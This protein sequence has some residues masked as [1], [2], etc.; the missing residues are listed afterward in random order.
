MGLP[1]MEDGRVILAVTGHRP[2]KIRVGT[3]NA[4]DPAVQGG[5]VEFA[6][7]I[8]EQEA[9][10]LVVT[11]MAQGWDQAVAEACLNTGLPYLAAVP[12]KEQ[13]GKWPEKAQ[14]VYYRL[15]SGAREIRYVSPPGFDVGK[16]HSRNLWM[17]DNGDRLLALYNGSGGGTGVCVRYALD[18]AKPVRNVWDDW[19]AFVAAGVR[20]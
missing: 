7:G 5:L 10:S 4:Y 13:A 12:F 11:G 2:D 3:K 15:L 20:A 1:R 6:T 8:L 14:K 18:V 16:L 9:P 19:C 17:V